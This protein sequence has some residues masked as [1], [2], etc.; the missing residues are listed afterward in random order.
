MQQKALDGGALD[1]IDQ[2]LR[3]Y[4]HEEGL[5]NMILVTIASLTDSGFVTFLR[6]QLV[7][8]IVC[9]YTTEVSFQFCSILGNS[10]HRLYRL[11]F[12]QTSFCALSEQCKEKLLSTSLCSTLVEFLQT[13][14]GDDNY[15]SVLDILIALAEWGTCTCF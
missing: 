5:C 1:I 12:C 15:E 11:I 9:L 6:I 2:Y 13:P 14:N 4:Q 8:I 3:Q 10:N 7:T